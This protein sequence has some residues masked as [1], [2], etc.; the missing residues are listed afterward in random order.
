M[1]NTKEGEAP[2][3]IGD[4]RMTGVEGEVWPMKPE[5]FQKNYEV[6][7]EEEGI[8]KKRKVLVD[9]KF[10][11]EDTKVTTSWG[12]L[13]T[14]KKGDAIVSASAEDRWV[15]SRSIFDATYLPEEVE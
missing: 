14:A 15:V 3:E 13:L 4:Y 1:E 10:A 7:N 11:K 6:I 12:A 2:Y 8:A 5:V 9:V